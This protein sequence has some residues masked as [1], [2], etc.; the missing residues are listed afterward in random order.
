MGAGGDALPGEFSQRRVKLAEGN[1]VIV[2]KSP[3]GLRGSK[4]GLPGTG[5][6]FNGTAE[7]VCGCHMLFNPHV[8][9]AVKP[10]I[11]PGKREIESMLKSN[12]INHKKCVDTYATRGEAYQC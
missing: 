5:D 1:A 11:R 6:I 10:G 7:R 8:I 2:E 3:D 12:N 9:S 4:G